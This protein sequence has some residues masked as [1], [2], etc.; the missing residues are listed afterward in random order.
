MKYRLIIAALLVI[1]VGMVNAE[2]LDGA[3]ILQMEA[4]KAREI[5]DL[6]YQAKLI[7]RKAKLAEA[8]KK[9][10]ESGGVIP[11]AG[12]ITARV[13]NQKPQETSSDL[14]VSNSASDIPSLITVDGTS[15]SFSYKGQQFRGK[16][17][18]TLPGGYR[19]LSVSSINGVRISHPSGT[20]YLDVDWSKLNK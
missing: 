8:Y 9:Y 14:P 20:Y 7:E 13:I 17:G 12:G 18:T 5:E 3:T 11:G 2:P 15:A 4:E 19:V 6:E 16:P 10:Q 1:P